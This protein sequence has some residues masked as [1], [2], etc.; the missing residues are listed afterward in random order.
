MPQH[1]KND[2]HDPKRTFLTDE[3]RAWPW[4]DLRTLGAW[5]VWPT[6]ERPAETT[7]DT[8]MAVRV[9]QS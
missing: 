1:R 5:V 2:V 3:C 7:V 8:F 9:L 6:T 4:S